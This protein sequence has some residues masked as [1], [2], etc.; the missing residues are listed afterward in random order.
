MIFKIETK[1][2]KRIDEDSWKFELL[3]PMD[4]LKRA[5]LIASL[6]GDAPFSTISS[7]DYNM[8]L[9]IATLKLAFREGPD[10]FKEKCNG[11]FGEFRDDEYMIELYKEYELKLKEFEEAKK[12]C[13]HNKGSEKR[14][15][16]TSFSHTDEI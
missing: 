9:I 15:V 4:K 1:F 16:D 7:E 6:L 10:W 13:R 12:K 11:N 2:T 3:R 5:S 8:A 14:K